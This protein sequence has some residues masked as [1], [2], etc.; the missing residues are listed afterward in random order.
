MVDP[1]AIRPWG[2]ISHGNAGPVAAGARSPFCAGTGDSGPRFETFGWAVKVKGAAGGA[3]LVAEAMMPGM[4]VTVNTAMRVRDVSKPL[5]HHEDD[6]RAKVAKWP[7]SPPRPAP[8]PAPPPRGPKGGTATP[9]PWRPGAERGEAPTPRPGSGRRKGQAR[10]SPQPPG[11]TSQRPPAPQASRGPHGP[12]QLPPPA[13][14]T[15]GQGP[16]PPAPRGAGQPPRHEAG[17]APRQ[18]P[19][20]PSR[21]EPRPAPAQRKRARRRRRGGQPGG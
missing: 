12:G 19:A 20:F 3:T 21:R 13:P 7:A 6:A 9:G 14:D 2:D 5:P 8:A 1:G 11:G 4:K 17:P 18:R 10:P 16:P 15:T